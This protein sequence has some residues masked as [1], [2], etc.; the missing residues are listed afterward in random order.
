MVIVLMILTVLTVLIVLATGIVCIIFIAWRVCKLQLL[1]VAEAEWDLQ[2]D[3]AVK[4]K[5]INLRDKVDEID[6]RAEA[7]LV[8]QVDRIAQRE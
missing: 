3:Q 8:D 4:V 5:R 7:R 2:V 6:R 1:Q